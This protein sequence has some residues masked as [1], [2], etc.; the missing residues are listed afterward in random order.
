MCSIHVFNIYFIM[1][2]LCM[3]VALFAVYMYNIG[4]IVKKTKIVSSV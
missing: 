3:Y 2:V 1:Y 4:T